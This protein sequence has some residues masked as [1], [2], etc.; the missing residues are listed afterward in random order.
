MSKEKIKYNNKIYK[1]EELIYYNG[2]KL[3]KDKKNNIILCWMNE[4][5][6]ED[7]WFFIETT[8]EKI[9]KYLNQE[10]TLRKI[11]KTSSYKMVKRKYIEYNQ[12]QDLNIHKENIIFPTKQSFLPFKYPY[13]K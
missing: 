7:I 1:F 9:K 5:E 4:T 12:L 10:I 8:S 2:P 13:T 3:Y 11:I 6:K